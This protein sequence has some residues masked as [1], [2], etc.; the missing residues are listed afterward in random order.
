MSPRRYILKERE[1][2][3]RECRRRG[4]TPSEWILRY[5]QGYHKKYAHKVLAPCFEGYK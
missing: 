2:M 1:I 4:I 5:A 3:E